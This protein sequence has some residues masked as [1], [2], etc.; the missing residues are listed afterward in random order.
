MGVQSLPAIVFKQL[1]LGSDGED[2]RHCQA[3]LLSKGCEGDFVIQYGCHVCICC[4]ADSVGRH[5][6]T[7]QGLIDTILS[8]GNRHKEIHRFSMSHIPDGLQARELWK[9]LMLFPRLIISLQKTKFGRFAIGQEM[10][11]Y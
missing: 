2:F 7:G 4:A 8:H 9:R 5:Q 11:S 3:V 6:F 1:L 10:H